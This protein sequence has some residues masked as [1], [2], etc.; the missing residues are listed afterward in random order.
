M[1][2]QF[3]PGPWV[4]KSSIAH[5][6]VVID[7]TD[8]VVAD[9]QRD[10]NNARLIAAAPDLYEACKVAATAEIFGVDGTI[11]FDVMQTVI[12]VAK[13]AFAKVEDKP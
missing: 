2:P 3:T 13:A 6:V 1:S 9:C 4:V 7:P 10:K 11:D 12:D 5:G 8:I